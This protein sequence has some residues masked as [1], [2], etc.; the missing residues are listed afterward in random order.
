MIDLYY[1]PTRSRCFERKRDWITQTGR[2]L[3]KD[4]RG[5]KTAMEWLFRTL[6]EEGKKILLGQ[7]DSRGRQPDRTGSRYST[8]HLNIG[9]QIT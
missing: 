5:R 9:A 1:R 8:S 4:V 2:F 3:P 6:T 7:T